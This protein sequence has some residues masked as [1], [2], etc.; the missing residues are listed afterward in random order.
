MQIRAEKGVVSE[1]NRTR[2]IDPYT[3]KDDYRYRKSAPKLR[4]KRSMGVQPH[5]GF[6]YFCGTPQQR[7]QRRREQRF[8]EVIGHNYHGLGGE[9]RP[10]LVSFQACFISAIRVR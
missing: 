10:P 5:Q 2:A 3:A 1:L 9:T 7:P 8:D 4:S 6:A